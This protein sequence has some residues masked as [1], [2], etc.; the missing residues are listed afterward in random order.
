MIYAESK[1]IRGIV[2][3]HRL[4]YTEKIIIESFNRKTSVLLRMSFVYPY[5]II[6]FSGEILYHLP[7]HY[8]LPGALDIVWDKVKPPLWEKSRA[9]PMMCY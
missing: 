5:F 9:V 4:L 8:T 6:E 7:I 1:S 3:F 2:L